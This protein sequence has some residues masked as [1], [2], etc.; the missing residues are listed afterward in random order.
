MSVL[1]AKSVRRLILTT[2]YARYQR[3]PLEMPGPGEFLDLGMTRNDLVFN[4]H[5]LS[6]RGLVEMMMGYN[7]PLFT[8]VR[9]TADGIDVVENHL[10]FNLHYPAAPE[11]QSDALGKLPE[12]VEGLAAEADLSPLEWERRKVLLSDIQFLRDEVARPLSRWRRP[13]LESLLN[14]IESAHDSPE[15][16]LPSLVP[17]RD[18]LST[19]D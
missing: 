19:L 15:E 3:D 5:Y 12:L 2:L 9:L 10:T 18:L 4:I 13:V 1:H 7:P 16:V 14:W 17:L 8:A 11:S 6:D